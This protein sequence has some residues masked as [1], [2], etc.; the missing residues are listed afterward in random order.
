[1]QRDDTPLPDMDSL[2]SDSVLVVGVPWDERST[3]LRG[4]AA[5]PRHIRAALHSD[6]SNWCAENGVDLAAADSTFVVAGDLDI[7]TGDAALTA[8]E[9]AFDG[10]ISRGARLIAL[11]GDHAI[12][13][14]ILRAM[15]RHRAPF[16]VLQIDAHADL[17]DEYDGDRYSHA[18]PFARVM[19]EGLTARLV[20][21]GIRTLN[22]HQREQAARFGTEVIE[23]RSFRPDRPIPFERPVF[24]SIDLDGFDPAF[25]PGVAH[26]EPGGFSTREVLN[27][28]GSIEVPIV[29]AD[30]VELQPTRDQNELTATLAA[31]LVKEI[32]GR[33]IQNGR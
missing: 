14:P 15:H 3:F 31:R 7:P 6:A 23:M 1:M 28:I 19:E 21:V 10:W 5:A 20:Q 13:V 29:G 25:A 24:L 4:A 11:G 26:P 17:Y 8:I 9:Q 32:A 30:I 16:D 22:P 12:T 2:S 18:C 33:M 27:L